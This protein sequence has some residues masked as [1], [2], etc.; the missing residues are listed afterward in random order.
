MI[1]YIYIGLIFSLG[2][3]QDVQILEKSLKE[4]A[5]DVTLHQLKDK[6]NTRNQSRLAFEVIAGIGIGEY[7]GAFSGLEFSPDLN[8]RLNVIY[9]PIS[10]ISVYTG[11][12]QFRF[13]CTNGLCDG[14]DVTF[15]GSGF[16]YGFQLNIYDFWISTGLIKHNL[17]STSSQSFKSDRTTWGYDLRAGFLIPINSLFGINFGVRY[18]NYKARFD[19]TEPFNS[20]TYLSSEFGLR[21]NLK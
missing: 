20:V 17:S 4:N 9:S 21:V 8:N 15:K 10:W 7:Q 18:S 5:Y 11:F 6:K 13:G 12:E 19:S 3:F 2:L 14:F 16:S 1:T